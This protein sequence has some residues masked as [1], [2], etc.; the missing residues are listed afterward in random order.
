V[1]ILTEILFL[2]IA[3][4][5]LGELAS[6]FKQPRI[7][8]EMVAGILLGPACFNVVIPTSRLDGI[9]E[10]SIFLIVISAGLEMDFKQV[11]GAFRGRQFWGAMFGFVIPFI[12][13]LGLGTLFQLPLMQTFFIALCI[14]ITALPVTI[15]ILQEFG[16]LNSAV[17]ELSISAAIVNDILGLLMLGVVLDLSKHSHG[18]T[19]FMAV[20]VPVLIGV[21]K[22]LGFAAIVWGMSRLLFWGS[23][24]GG[25]IEK[26][27]HRLR[28]LF[29]REVIF[30]VVIFFV[31]IF[32][33][34]SESLG[35]HFIVGT[36]FGALLISNDLMGGQ[37]YQDVE[38]T[39]NSVSAGFLSPVF[40]GYLGLLFTWD[41]FSNPVLLAAVLFV[42][43]SSKIL[44]GF[45]AG[46]WLKL[47]LGESIG[48]GIMLNARGIMELVVANLGLQ[49]KLIDHDL[50]SILVIMGMVTTILTPPLFRQFALPRL[51]P[52][53][54]KT[55]GND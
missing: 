14:S 21:V 47:S 42:A 15:R 30:G 18:S 23:G 13:G 9:A 44:A 32:G 48:T 33:S 31:L 35:T 1:H 26:G 43:I 50:F 51:R 45:L 54:V 40:F 12:C 2:L 36:F 10:L 53:G 29:G 5:L 6:H 52:A 37:F 39:L 38:Q 4:R 28:A 3:C 11:V 49:A 34:M 17:A 20:A 22:V 41:G 55:E 7:L 24:E 8:G 46:R 16:L 25:Y 19:D 27:L